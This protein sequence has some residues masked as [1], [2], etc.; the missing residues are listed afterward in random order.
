[1][2][3]GPTNTPINTKYYVVWEQADGSWKFQ[4]TKAAAGTSTICGT[5]PSQEEAIRL[6][7]Q[8]VCGAFA[9]KNAERRRR[10]IP[11]IIGTKKK[12]SKQTK[13]QEDLL[14]LPT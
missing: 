13:A 12:R 7:K 8:S 11:L 5:A 2:Y 14:P 9:R 3:F 6:A 1:M 10:G 4:L